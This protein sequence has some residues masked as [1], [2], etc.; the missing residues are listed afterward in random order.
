MLTTTTPTSCP[1]IFDME[2][3]DGDDPDDPDNDPDDPD[4][5]PDDPGSPPWAPS[6]ASASSLY[7]LPYSIPLPPPIA[8]ALSLNIDKFSLLR[9]VM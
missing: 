2:I 6:T 7:S 3:L 1:D 5:D 9:G 8:M 4:N